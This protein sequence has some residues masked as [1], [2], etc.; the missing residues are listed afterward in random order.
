MYSIHFKEGNGDDIAYKK[1]EK[2][3]DE[4]AFHSSG[5]RT[6]YHIFYMAIY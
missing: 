1:Q 2:E 4:Y 6:K 5:C 3:N